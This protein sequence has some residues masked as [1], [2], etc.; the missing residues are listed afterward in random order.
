[1]PKNVSKI[2]I[3]R[4]NSSK[5]QH[6]ADEGEQSLGLTSRIITNLHYSRQCSIGERIDT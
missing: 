6:I 4:Q 5:S 3:E 1:M 2:Y